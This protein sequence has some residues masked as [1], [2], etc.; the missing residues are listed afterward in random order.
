MPAVL[1]GNVMKDP[2]YSINYHTDKLTIEAA[3]ERHAIKSNF[4]NKGV[5]VAADKE[6]IKKLI[7]L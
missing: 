2:T 5:R 7:G 6:A 4:A 3:G 1:T